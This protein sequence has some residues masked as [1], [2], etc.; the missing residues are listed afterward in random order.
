MAWESETPGILRESPFFLGFCLQELFWIL[1]VKNQGRYPSWFCQ[2]EKKV[3]FV[4]YACSVLHKKC[5]HSRRKERLYQILI[6]LGERAF[7]WGFQSTLVFLAN[8]RRREE[9]KKPLWRSHFRKRPTKRLGFNHKIIEHFP[10]LHLNFT[11]TGHM[12]NNSRLKWKDT[13]AI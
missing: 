10:S 12:F 6:Q 1:M 8:L 13:G 2:C 4:K 7:P 11:P 9:M 5:L 3:T